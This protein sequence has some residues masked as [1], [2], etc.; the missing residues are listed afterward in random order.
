L[1]KKLL[2]VIR[3]LISFF[4]PLSIFFHYECGSVPGKEQIPKQISSI[5][6]D[7]IYTIYLT[8]DDGPLEGS[9]DI[10]DAVKKENVKVNVF[11][12]GMHALA[13][14][15]MSRFYS[16]YEANPYI[17]IG[18][19]SFTHAFDHYKNYY[20]KPDSVFLDFEKNQTRLQI[21]NRLARLPGRNMWRLKGITMNDVNTGKEAADL[22]YR[23]GYKVFGWDIEWQHSGET[24]IPVQSVNEM[25][26]IIEK[27]LSEGKTIRKNHLVLL[28][29]DEMFRNG[30]EESELKQLITKLKAK[31]NYR[32]EHLSNYPD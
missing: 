18:N 23:N 12:V 15:R 17:E 1:T 3:I 28:S 26:E 8:F 16:L 7:S 30:W 20:E 13:N 5:P 27:K 24:G 25:I 21:R 6:G 9:E 10:N 11:V 2:P 4:I 14:T 29:H 22:L 32:F 19:H 31:G